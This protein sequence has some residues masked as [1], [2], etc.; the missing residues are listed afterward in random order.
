[1]ADKQ[2]PNPGAEEAKEEEVKA[3][4]ETATETAEAEVKAPEKKEKSSVPAEAFMEDIA[5]DELDP[6]LKADKIVEKGG[7]KYIKMS[8][9]TDD[10]YSLDKYADLEKLY[11]ESLIDVKEGEIVSGKII[12]ISEK[13][14]SVDIGFKSEGVVD[15]EE[16]TDP[17]SLKVGD[18]I[19]VFLDSVE[20]AEGMLQL[21]KRKADF[22]RV[23]DRVKNVYAADGIIRGRCVRRIKGGMVVDLG[24][25]D[26]FLPG[27]QIDVRPVRD[28][29]A[30]I[31]TEME[32]KILK[33]NDLRKNIVVSHKVL[34]EEELREV[35]EKL[36]S[37]LDVGMELEGTVKNITDFGVF[38]D[39]G[40]V[41]GLLHITDLSWGRVSHPSEVVQLD[42]KIRVKVLNY[43][44][45]R[46][47]I[48]LGLKQLYEHLWTEIDKKYRVGQKIQGRVVSLAKYG[49]FI[50]IEPGI[51]GLVHISEMSWTQHIK[52][53]NQVVHENEFVQVVVLN[54]DKENKKISL[55]LK[56]VEQ[57][58]WENFEAKYRVDTRHKGIVRDLVPF[59]AFVELADGIDGLVHISDLSWTKKVRHPGEI[60][61]K[62]DEVEVVV[63]SFDR[64]ER[65]IA[66]GIKQTEGNPWEDFEREMPVGTKTT[67]TAARLIDK[68]VIIELPHGIEGFLPNSQI[69][70][71]YF[72]GKKR[73]L[74]VGDVLNIVVVEFDKEERKVILS[75]SQAEKKEDSAGGGASFSES[76]PSGK[77][78]TLADTLPEDSPLLQAMKKAEAEEAKEKKAKTSKKKAKEEDAEP[79]TGAAE[80]EGEE[81]AAKPK[82]KKTAKKE[83]EAPAETEAK[84][85]EATETDESAPAEE[86]SEE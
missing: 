70:R 32:F 29:D 39:L 62:G 18:E 24:G 71:K 72:D 56:Q 5:L 12:A 66:L 64:D 10:V 41:D 46:K 26:A 50:E 65:R 2:T 68:G 19:D 51:E 78:A 63:L 1:M 47:R 15:I 58:P 53:P 33:I 14:V 79:E 4:V 28:F 21:S 76:K 11:E 81:E 22:M 60:L 80:A 52:H 67:G 54:I 74:Q 83:E 38:V 25:V 8:D 82:A 35:R 37:N 36:L 55:G 23:W 9:L 69:S 48:S 7:E 17:A 43:D 42:Q 77:T 57:D 6:T 3:E 73:T 20:D 34:K 75:N 49:A 44:K 40:G 86:A 31:G 59:G 45:E 85:E 61:K 27:S 13:E 16:F 84:A 30:I